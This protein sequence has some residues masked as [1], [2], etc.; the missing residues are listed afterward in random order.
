[1]KSDTNQR[2]IDAAEYETSL[3]VFP[4]RLCSNVFTFLKKLWL[5]VLNLK[6]TTIYWVYVLAIC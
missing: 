4:H 5:H 2:L 6:N 1:M 3:I